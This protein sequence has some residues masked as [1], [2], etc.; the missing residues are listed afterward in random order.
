[1]LFKILQISV[2]T[3]FCA[4]ITHA[5]LTEVFFDNHSEGPYNSALMEQD[6]NSVDVY[7]GPGGRFNILSDTDNNTNKFL[8]VTY[9]EGR[10]GA[11]NSGGQFITHLTPNDEYFLDYYIRFDDNFD[12]Q[13]GGKI[14][15]LS[16]GRSNTGGNRPTGDGWSARFMWREEGKAVV[17]LYHMDQPTNY[18][19][20]INLNRSFKRGQWHRLTQRIKVNSGNNNDGIL[21]VWFDGELVILRNDIRYRNNNRAPVDH[22]YFSTFF[23]GNTP[24]WAPDITSTISYDNIRLSTNAEDIVPDGEGILLTS[25]TRPSSGVTYEGPATIEIEATAFAMNDNI[26]SVSLYNGEQE[27]IR[28]NAEPYTYT[29]QDVP[30]GV[31]TLTA[32]VQDSDQNTTTSSPITVT[33]SAPDAEK[34]PNLALNKPVSTSSE[35]E[36][37]QGQGAVDGSTFPDDRWSALGFPQSLTIDLENT[38]DIDLVE[39]LPYQNRA[40]QYTVESSI[41]GTS[42]T[43]LLD[44]SNNTTEGNLFTDAVPLTQARYLRLSVSGAHNYSGDWTS[45]IEFRA[46]STDPSSYILGDASGDRNITAFDASIVFKIAIGLLEPDERLMAIADVTGNGTVNVLDAMQ[47][48][49]YTVGL[50]ECFPGDSSNCE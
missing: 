30:P 20:D 31:Y 21:Q 33:V 10:V 19:H 39:L 25:I 3:L 2:V 11:T 43:P 47:V 8:R 44:R 1:M 6:F 41:D 50:I 35:Q 14:P 34:G 32:Q 49:Q 13:L 16:G 42:F 40:Y 22:F 12:F 29:W 28:F 5:Q 15:G 18:G 48:L 27:L 24:E 17:Y 23:G 45:I 7:N 26:Q 37:N 38:Y 46:F 4:Q 36:G 9:P